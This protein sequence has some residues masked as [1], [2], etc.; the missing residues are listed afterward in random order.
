MR[1]LGIA[2]SLLTSLCL[3]TAAMAAESDTAP[4]WSVDLQPQTILVEQT[5]DSSTHLQLAV[6]LI[7]S[8]FHSYTEIQNR[9]DEALATIE[10][11]VAGFDSADPLRGRDGMLLLRDRL[12]AALNARQ[13]APT[14][15]DVAFR[16]LR[17]DTATVRVIPAPGFAAVGSADN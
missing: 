17:I 8:D 10:E 12:V 7:A 5:G 13:F 11:T 1:A 6:T 15:H 14:V 9:R 4:V 16:T 3:G 2:F